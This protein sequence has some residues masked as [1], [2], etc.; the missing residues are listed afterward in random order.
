MF[1]PDE[2][3]SQF[4]VEVYRDGNEVTVI[5]PSSVDITP[6]QARRFGL[7]LIAAA[8]WQPPLPEPP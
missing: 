1:W 4:R 5:L 7:A 2:T 3:L 6:E 8:D